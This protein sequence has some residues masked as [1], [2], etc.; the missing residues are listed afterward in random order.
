MPAYTKLV[1]DGLNTTQGV[2]KVPVVEP[3]SKLVKVIVDWPA[4][5]I[6]PYWN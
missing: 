3:I 5:V 4:R 1:D 6:E 2:N